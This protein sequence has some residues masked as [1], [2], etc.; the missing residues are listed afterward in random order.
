MAGDEVTVVGPESRQPTPQTPGMHR[1][2]AYADDDRWAGF[3]QTDSGMVSGWHHH[4]GWNTYIYVLDGKLRM[5]FGPGGSSSVEAGP[6]D[7]VHVP[8]HL[9]HREGNPADQTASLIVFRAGHGDIIVNTD[10][11]EPA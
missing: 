8:A 6:G 5:E 10:G 2:A 4:D 3:V 7:F 9:V 11:P 1:E